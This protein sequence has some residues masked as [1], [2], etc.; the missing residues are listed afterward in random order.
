MSKNAVTDWDSTAANNTDIGG[1]NIAEGCLAAG[2]NDA[3][4]AVMAQIKAFIT[5]ALFYTPNAGTTGGV[6]VA[7]NPTSGNAILQFVDSTATNQWGYI[8]VTSSGIMNFTDSGGIAR[9]IGYRNIPLTTKTTSFQI[10]LPY[11]GEGISTTAGITVPPNSTTAFTIGDTVTI[12]NNS[13]SSITIT[14]GAGVTL[15]LVGTSTTGSRTVAQR[16]L[17]TLLK[18]GVDEWVASGGGVS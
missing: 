12:Y 8:S 13:A 16:G 11:V 2:I 4:R 18:I 5:G 6:R 3:I 7:G 17:C 9:P 1:I 14:P 10:D 15:R